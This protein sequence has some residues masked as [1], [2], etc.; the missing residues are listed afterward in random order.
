MKSDGD[1]VQELKTRRYRLCLDFKKYFE[2]YMQFNDQES[3]VI[4][5]QLLNA[6]DEGIL[7]DR[8]LENPD[9]QNILQINEENEPK[10]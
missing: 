9:K 10:I 1:R 5:M 6:F 3:L 2:R 7:K 4:C 8:N